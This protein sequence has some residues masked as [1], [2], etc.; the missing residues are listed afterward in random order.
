MRFSYKTYLSTT[1]LIPIAIIIGV[2][3]FLFS[4]SYLYWLKG[5][6]RRK[7]LTDALKYILSTIV[8]ISL[9]FVPCQ[10][11]LHGGI[12]LFFENEQDALTSKGVVEYICEP[13][14]RFHTFKSNHKYGADIV[15]DGECYFVIT[16]G[17]INEGDYIEIQYLPQSHFILEIHK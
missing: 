2:L 8:S 4:S 12:Y 6:Y 17:D 5:M 15:I 11:L 9:L 16:A 13:S 14:E 1:F 3:I 10:Y 7:I